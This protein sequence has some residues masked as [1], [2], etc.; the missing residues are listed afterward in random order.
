MTFTEFMKAFR[1]VAR[2]RS[3]QVCT[4]G[5]IRHRSS[6]HCPLS[7]VASR[8]DATVAKCSVNE[9]QRLLGL[10]NLDVLRIID[11]ADHSDKRPITRKMLL[12][13]IGR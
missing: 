4:D 7:W 1:K 13:A 8:V 11:A 9:P 12:E 10:N 3:W 6:K 2:P 5:A